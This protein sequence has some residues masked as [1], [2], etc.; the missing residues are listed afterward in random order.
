VKLIIETYCYKQIS[1]VGVKMINAID[2][3]FWSIKHTQKKL[4]GVLDVIVCGVF[5]YQASLLKDKWIFERS[6]NKLNFL[7]SKFWHYYT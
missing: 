3:R 2:K 7:K 1:L 6:D 4:F 5:V